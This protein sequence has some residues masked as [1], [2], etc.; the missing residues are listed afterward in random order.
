MAEIADFD[1]LTTQLGAAPSF[2]DAE[3]QALRLDSG[4]RSDGEPRLELDIHLFVCQEIRGRISFVNHTLATMAFRGIEGVELSG[5]WHQNV[6]FDISLRDISPEA[7]SG[8]RVAVELSASN[9]VS[10]AFRCREVAVIAVAP[11]APGAHSVYGRGG[12]F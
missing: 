10:G 11:F 4:Q 2:H 7:V 9:G 6:L 3:I 12:H 8:A 5:F 1:L